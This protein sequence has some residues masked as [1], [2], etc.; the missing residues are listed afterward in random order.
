MKSDD[1]NAWQEVL[2]DVIF[3]SQ[4]INPKRIAF[5]LHRHSDYLSDIC[6]R[7]RVDPFAVANEI[8]KEAELQCAGDLPRFLAVCRPILA[9]LID[10]TNWMPT[11]VAPDVAANLSYTKL[12][13]H[14][15]TLCEDIGGAIKALAQ[16]EADGQYDEQD[17]TAIAEFQHKAGLL[18]HRLSALGMELQ[19]RRAARV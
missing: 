1:M 8:L 11:Y 13:E 7:E 15:G 6:R 17:D 10:G 3:G 9:L 19:R 12:C 4:L 16:I 2:H 14:T 18:T 5:R